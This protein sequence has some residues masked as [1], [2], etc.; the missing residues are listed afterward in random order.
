MMFALS[1]TNDVKKKPLLNISF[2]PQKSKKKLDK[3]KP[4]VKLNQRI[5]MY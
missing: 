2:A 5:T 3:N 4:L 1:A